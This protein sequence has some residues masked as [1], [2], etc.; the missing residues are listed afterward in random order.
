MHQ[1][2][3]RH[4]WRMSSDGEVHTCPPCTV[5]YSRGEHFQLPVSELRP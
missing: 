4:G 2:I 3:A 1:A 5:R